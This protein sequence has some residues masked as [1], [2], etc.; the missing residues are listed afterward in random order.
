[1]GL[2]HPPKKWACL[3]AVGPA[4]AALGMLLAG[5]VLTGGIPGGPELLIL[6]LLLGALSPLAVGVG[7]WVDIGVVE[8]ETGVKKSRIAW[9]VGGFLLPPIVGTVYLLDRRNHFGDDSPEK[10]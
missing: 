3:V 1:M 7:T 2:L 9:A 8:R 6:W 10:V 4:F 5:V